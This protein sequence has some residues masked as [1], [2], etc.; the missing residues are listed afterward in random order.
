M[1]T[2]SKENLSP[3]FSKSASLDPIEVHQNNNSKYR[4]ID[5]EYKPDLRQPR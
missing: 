5:T 2:A 3:F 1:T 4:E